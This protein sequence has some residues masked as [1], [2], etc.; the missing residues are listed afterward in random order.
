MND[1]LRVVIVAGG[2]AHFATVNTICEKSGYSV[3]SCFSARSVKSGSPVLPASSA[4]AGDLLEVLPGG[5]DLVL[6]GSAAGLADA[7]PGYRPDIVVACGF[8]WKFPADVLDIPE[9]GV[10]NIHPSLLPKH[11]GP[12]PIAWAIRNGATTFGLTVH[13]MDEEFDTGEIL[14]SRGGI[15]LDE[16][17]TPERLWD[18]MDPVLN[19]LLPDALGK[20]VAGVPG[21]PQ[22]AREASREPAFEPAFY[23]VDWSNTTLE[24]HNQVRA[25]R[26]MGTGPVAQ[27]G[28]RRIRVLRTRLDAGAGER[29]E[30]ADGPLWIVE[31]VPA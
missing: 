19:D 31:S 20:V 16:D 18:R 6:P 23:R 4:A 3:V 27:I 9:F 29:V 10:L 15:P 25:L 1:A 24:V 8:P 14:C 11:R 21:H 17:P 5:M 12:M 30:C 26:S 13:R 22:D 28:H 7:L 2:A